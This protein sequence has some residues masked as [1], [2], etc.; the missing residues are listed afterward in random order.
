MV[1]RK[2]VL[3]LGLFTCF[4]AVQASSLEDGLAAIESENFG[5]AL[6]ILMPLANEGDP[7]A[8]Y[9][10][11]GLYHNGWGVEQDFAAS[12][13]WFRQAAD[14]G[15]ARAKTSL[16][17]MYHYGRTVG[18]DYEQAASWYQLAANDGDTSAQVALAMMFD[19]GL[20]VPQSADEAL[21]QM[22]AAAESGDSVAQ[23]NMGVAYS[24]G[25]WVP[26]DH[27]AAV[28]WYRKSAEQ[29]NVEGAFQLGWKYQHGKGIA[30]SNEAARKWYREAWDLDHGHDSAREA[31]MA[32]D[33]ELAEQFKGAYDGKYAKPCKAT[34]EKALK[35]AEQGNAKWQFCVGLKYSDGYKV[36]AK[37]ESEI[38]WL[39]KFPIDEA[40]A[41]TYYL[42]SFSSPDVAATGNENQ[43]VFWLEKAAEQDY[44]DAQRTVALN[45]Y[46]GNG[47]PADTSKSKYWLRKAI[48]NDDPTAM[49]FWGWFEFGEF[50]PDHLAGSFERD[51]YIA[52]DGLFRVKYLLSTGRNSIDSFVPETGVGTVSLSNDLGA[53][54]GVIYGPATTN[55]LED[56]FHSVPMHLI[57]SNIPEASILREEGRQIH[58]MDSWIAVVEMPGGGVMAKYD[59]EKNT[60]ES[61]DSVR[62]FVV[63]KRNDYIFALMCEVNIMGFFEQGRTYDPENWDAF[64]ADLSDFYQHMSF[65]DKKIEVRK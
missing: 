65:R 63:F 4:Q 27:A 5:D 14:Q 60:Y 41:A 39:E 36:K 21:R 52:P 19:R 13:K 28:E 11:G 20:G 47:V 7:V 31:L 45:Y 56:W 51:T 30:Q 58:G 25:Y 53:L 33:K 18:V 43:A 44:A 57:K 59:A 61:S 62:G 17:F 29:Q 16:A 32:L 2:V 50:D 37:G 22:T 42:G 26:Q 49:E 15:Y 9:V 40:A 64:L 1:L 23:H 35:R 34:F 38:Y 48:E 12:I 6:E 24:T 54:N 46:Y 10:I 8:Q 55:Q 3:I